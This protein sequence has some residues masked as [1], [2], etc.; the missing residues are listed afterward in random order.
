VKDTTG[1]LKDGVLLIQLPKIKDRR[2]SE[3]KVPITEIE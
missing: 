1:E 2:G 3:F